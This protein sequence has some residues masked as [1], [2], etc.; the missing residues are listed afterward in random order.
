MFHQCNTLIHE[1]WKQ[2]HIQETLD[3]EDIPVKKKLAR[4]EN[5]AMETLARIL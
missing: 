1:I 5:L 3:L 4:D 2:N